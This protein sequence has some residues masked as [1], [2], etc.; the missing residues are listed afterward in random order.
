MTRTITSTAPLITALAVLAALSLPGRSAA[1]ESTTRGFVLGAHV[2]ASSIKVEDADRGNG[3]GG[4]LF[5]G[6]GVN[7][8]VTIFG[9]VDGSNI[10]V[11]NQP[12][13]EG[14]WTMAHVDLGVRF[15]FANSL[16]SY[17]P[18]LEG[19]FTARAVEVS[20]LPANNAF[21]VDSY[22]FSG[23]AFTLGGGV[24]IY[25]SQTLAFD[26]GL[27]FSGGEFTDITVGNTTRG[28]FDLDTQSTRFNVGVAW[29]L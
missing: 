21:G 25:A 13:A 15:N 9:R 11:E 17:V 7:R 4:G 1:Q 28:G 5:I 29:W 2:G 24:M 18:Y 19:A 16:R 3:G 10:E 12:D 14:T 27:L 22:S 8:R 20:D 23:G 6:Y 26:L